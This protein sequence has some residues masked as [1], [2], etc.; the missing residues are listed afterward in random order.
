[1]FKPPFMSEA[2]ALDHCIKWIEAVAEQSDE[3]SINPM[4]IQRG[5]VIDRLHRHREYRPPW[6]WS[7]VELIQQSH[8]IVHPDGGTNADSGQISRLIIHPTAGGKVRGSHNCGEC[9]AEVVAAIERYA[10][11]GSLMS[12]KVSIV[13]AKAVGIKNSEMTVQFQS[14]WE[15]SMPR[16]GSITEILRSP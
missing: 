15:P 12:S 10:V 9:D 8:H 13:P 6:L 3:I 1:M 14:H 16:R 7:L 11:S 2:D 4:N 5:T